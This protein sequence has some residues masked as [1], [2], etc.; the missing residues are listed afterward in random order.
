MKKSSSVP[1]TLEDCISK[2][3]KCE[4]KL[5]HEVHTIIVDLLRE[6][7][8]YRESYWKVT[9]NKNTKRPNYICSDCLKVQAAPVKYC[10]NC[11]RAKVDSDG[12]IKKH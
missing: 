4:R 8:T 3:D 1:V 7:V 11:G 5:G 9:R 2:V 6:A 12:N 10:P